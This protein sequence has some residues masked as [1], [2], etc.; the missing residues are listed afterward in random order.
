[1]T[2]AEKIRRNDNLDKIEIGDIIDK[3]IKGNFGKVLSFMLEELKT[4][5]TDASERY[6]NIPADRILGRIES[7]NKIQFRLDQCVD[8]KNQLREEVK[9]EKA[10]KPKK[11]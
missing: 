10:V 8:M 7:L 11:K 2:I 5:A 9:E 6:P 4:E 1:M 3:A